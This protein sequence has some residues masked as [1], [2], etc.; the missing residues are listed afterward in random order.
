MRRGPFTFFVVLSLS[1][2]GCASDSE[3]NGSGSPDAT[4]GSG[5][6]T[7]GGGGAHSGGSSGKASGGGSSSGGGGNASGGSDT[8]GSAGTGGTSNSGGSATA[9]DASSSGGAG[10]V[11]NA[12][13]ADAATHM[14]ASIEAGARDAG[15][16]DA[17]ADGAIVVSP[18][19]T[20]RF[21]GVAPGAPP[22]DVCVKLTSDSSY[23]APPALAAHGV[24]TGL[25]YRSITPYWDFGLDPQK[26]YD[27]EFVAA[28]AHACAPPLYGA[29]GTRRFPS[30]ASTTIAIYEQQFSPVAA[31]N[32]AQIVDQGVPAKSGA[33][34]R[35]YYA[36]QGAGPTADFRATL[37]SGSEATWFSAVGVGTSTAF[38][39]TA[40]GSYSFRVTSGAA[41]TVLAQASGV[42]L[43]AGEW[44]DV[45]LI[46]TS[47][48]AFALLRC[49]LSTATLTA[50]TP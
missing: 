7:S 50:C 23:T 20:I 17:R 9:G 6:A 22:L 38:H 34:V 32:G 12:G 25:P 24:T 47:A 8:G 46:P 3:S 28:S 40:A 37:G 2:D 14:D 18:P 31:Y 11:S 48:T 5:G 4:A 29:I 41:P 33:S 35:F 13:G 42:T 26:F 1:L 19:G 45:F 39:S 44:L 30:D 21:V 15:T 16:S 10:G 49:P 27:F 43:A 36:S